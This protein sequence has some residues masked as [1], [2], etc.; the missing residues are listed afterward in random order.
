MDI[1][2][3]NI[4]ERIY[5]KDDIKRVDD[6]I[7]LFGISKKISTKYYLKVRLFSSLLVL[8][9]IFLLLDYGFFYGPI[10]SLIW[11]Y[12]L[13]YFMIDTPLKKR[14]KQLEHQAFYYFEVLTL[15]LESG[16]NLETSIETACKY[17]DSE[18]SSEFRET[19]LQIRLGKSLTEALTEMRF[20]IPSEAV[21]NII[22][23]ITQSTIFGSSILDT[24]YNQLDFLRDKQI[25][26]IKSEISKIPTKI[27]ILSVLFFV[28]LMMILILSPLIIE[29]ISTS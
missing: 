23:N 21:N 26:N 14:A 22:L 5:S 17:I 11:Y 18:V 4:I 9:I 15:T 29:F 12:S 3:T 13:Y 6:K 16:R 10:V 25:L 7:R 28:P 1:K 8:I 24:M 27:S 20:R 19:L 2:G